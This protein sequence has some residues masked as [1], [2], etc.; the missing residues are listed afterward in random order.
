MYISLD[1]SQQSPTK[2]MLPHEYFL[3]QLAYTIGYA[4]NEFFLV[5]ENTAPRYDYSTPQHLIARKNQFG[6]VSAQQIELI[7]AL[8]ESRIKILKLMNLYKIFLLN[9]NQAHIV[10]LNW[11]FGLLAQINQ[12]QFTLGK[13]NIRQNSR[14]IERS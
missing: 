1:T 12:K 9:I 7:V 6:G 14:S 10:V 2:P 13:I 5:P 11:R 8:E 4:E 3:S